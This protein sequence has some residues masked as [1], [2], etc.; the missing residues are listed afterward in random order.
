[1]DS[2][3]FPPSASEEP[4]SNSR[5]RVYDWAELSNRVFFNIRSFGDPSDPIYGVIYHYQGDDYI[6]DYGYL[7]EQKE[8]NRFA[9][10]D[11]GTGEVSFDCKSSDLKELAVRLVKDRY[12]EEVL[13]KPKPVYKP[14]RC[15]QPD[16]PHPSAEIPKA[17]VHAPTPEEI[18]RRNRECAERDS[19]PRSRWTKKDIVDICRESGV[20]EK[21]IEVLEKMPLDRIFRE[22]MVYDG[23]E[24]TGN[25]YNEY[26]QRHTKFYRIDFC[27]MDL[28][29]FVESTI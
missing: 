14:A 9:R 7:M 19:R 1:M 29:G 26:Q 28:L 15:N 3:A 17:P 11:I 6:V 22:C 20:P 21:S 18:A 10:L 23:T 5:F 2:S 16:P 4:S 12:A 24:I 8:S 13:E 27:E 25:E